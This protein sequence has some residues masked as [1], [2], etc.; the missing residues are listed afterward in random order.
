MLDLSRSLTHIP[1]YCGRSIYTLGNM[2]GDANV[3]DL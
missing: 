2:L 3:D 1:P